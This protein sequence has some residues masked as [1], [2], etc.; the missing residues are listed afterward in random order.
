MDLPEESD[1]A[2]TTYANAGDV[3]AAAAKDPLELLDPR[4]H[5]AMIAVRARAY[6]QST[7]QAQLS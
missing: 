4:A 3:L 1:E 5:A 6:V 7:R 2:Y